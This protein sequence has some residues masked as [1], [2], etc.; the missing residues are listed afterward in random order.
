MNQIS[1]YFKEPIAAEGG[2]DN[3][4]ILHRPENEVKLESYGCV[5]RFSEN[6]TLVVP[7]SSIAWI[8]A[9]GTLE[10]SGL[11]WQASASGMAEPKS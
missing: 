7:W 10:A 6:E 1:V 3:F 9:E 4:Q 2:S 11:V 5:I 8:S